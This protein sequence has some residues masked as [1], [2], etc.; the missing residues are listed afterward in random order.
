MNCLGSFDSAFRSSVETCSLTSESP[1]L[2]ESIDADRS[3]PVDRS[4]PLGPAVVDPA[5]PSQLT[6]FEAGPVQ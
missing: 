2:M 5:S 1:S 6:S 4:G 3:C